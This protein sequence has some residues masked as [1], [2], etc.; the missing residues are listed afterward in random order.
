MAGAAVAALGAFAAAC[1]PS[2]DEHEF[3]KSLVYGAGSGSAGQAAAGPTGPAP[4]LPSYPPSSPWPAPSGSRNASPPPTASAAQPLVPLTVS[5]AGN[6]GARVHR[7]CSDNGAMRARASIYQAT[8]LAIVPVATPT[9]SI[10][11]L[12][13]DSAYSDARPTPVTLSQL[14]GSISSS[15]QMTFPVDIR[16]MTTSPTLYAIV[17]TGAG[18]GS[19]AASGTG[20][21]PPQDGDAERFPENSGV[22]G[23]L[24]AHFDMASQMVVATARSQLLYAANPKVVKRD[25]SEWDGPGD[26]CGCDDYD[27]PLVFDLSPSRRGVSLATPATDL[28]DID[29]DGTRDR[30]PWLASADTPLLAFDAND[31]GVVDGIDELFGNQTR[32]PS[33]RRESKNG[34]DALAEHDAN[35]DGVIDRGDAVWSRL[36]LWFDR[37]GD[38]RTGRG[39]LEPLAA[40]AIRSIPVGYV[41]VNESLVTAGEVFG[42]IRQRGAAYTSDGVAIPVVD[43]WFRR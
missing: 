5:F 37:N 31:N 4:S 29:G 35:R 33:G 16:Y 14:K 38:G 34:F 26:G 36:R 12:V 39:E 28:F 15:G 41:S 7:V 11:P 30:L 1:S 42:A 2:Y 3:S 13:T 6:S 8:G 17:A 10:S 22:V 23:Y 21:A 25:S 32:G 20:I 43:V 9:G 40:R 27:S 24:E 18:F 19:P